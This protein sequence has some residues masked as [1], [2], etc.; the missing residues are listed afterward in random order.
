MAT[1]HGFEVI[2]TF[3]ITMGRYR[4]FLQGRCACHFHEVSLDAGGNFWDG[5]GV[6]SPSPV[7]FNITCFFFWLQVEKLSSSRPS[8]DTTT[9]SASATRSAP[10][11]HS[12][13]ARLQAASN[14][15]SYHVRGPVNQVYSEILLSRLCPRTT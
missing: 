5:G 4:D 2:D 9:L 8:D 15:P 3:A 14:T 1:H 12:H 7:T 6:T 10:D 13:S 11:L